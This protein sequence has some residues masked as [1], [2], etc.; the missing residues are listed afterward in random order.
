[1]EVARMVFKTVC[2]VTALVSM[3]RMFEARRNSNTDALIEEGFRAVILT[4]LWHAW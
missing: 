2:A 3:V 4:V 1:M